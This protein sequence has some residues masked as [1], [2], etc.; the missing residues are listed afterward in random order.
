ME[1]PVLTLPYPWPPTDEARVAQALAQ[2][3]VMAYP[4]ETAYALG[5]N[6]LAADLVKRIYQLK[7]RPADK[8]L[9]VL[10]GGMEML[11]ALV[12]KVPS[13][14]QRLMAQFWPGPLTLVVRAGPHT[15]AHL[16]DARN[17]V[18]LRWSSSPVVAALLAL[19][20]VPLLGTS[21]NRSGQPPLY[22]SRQV[23]QTFGNALALLI[24]HDPQPPQPPSTLVDTTTQPPTLLRQGA[25]PWDS[26]LE[27]L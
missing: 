22:Q 12:G 27:A 26:I 21:A 18:A 20:G 10:I 24:A 8:A 4:T 2:A 25:L 16:M 3:Q 13:E 15:P 23:A 7:G 6:A 9:P 1:N 11:E 19:G 14:A 5:G 17:T